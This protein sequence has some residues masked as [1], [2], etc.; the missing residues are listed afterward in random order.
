MPA[1]DFQAD[2]DPF[3]ETAFWELITT[4]NGWKKYQLPDENELDTLNKGKAEG[5]LIG[6]NL[7]LLTSLI[8]TPYLPHFAGNILFIEEI[9]ESPYRVDR[10]L[11]Q[12]ALSGLLKKTSGVILGAFT[13]CV[14][15]EP[16][17]PTLELAEIFQTYLGKL[18]IPVLTGFPNGHIKTFPPLVYGV[19]VKINCQKKTFKFSESPFA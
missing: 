2:I 19:Q 12:L 4:K 18:K 11:N 3:T 10:M 17:K 5:T 7:S 9:A 1:V 13:D 8:G 14:E 6:G 16:G 15:T